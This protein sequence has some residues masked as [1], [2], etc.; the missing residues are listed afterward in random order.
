MAVAQH[1][2]NSGCSVIQNGMALV[3][4][5]DLG[6]HRFSVA[7]PHPLRLHAQEHIN[8]RG[9]RSLILEIAVGVVAHASKIAAVHSAYFK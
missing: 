5:W 9:V 1:H 3:L 6:K 7:P 8:K 2:T 4:T